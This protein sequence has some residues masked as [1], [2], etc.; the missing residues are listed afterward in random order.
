ML[1]RLDEWTNGKRPSAG[2]L[3]ELY[4]ATQTSAS[5]RNVL[6]APQKRAIDI[7][8]FMGRWYVIGHIPTFLDRGTINNT[9]DY[10]WDE[11]KQ[12][13]NVKF[14]YTVVGK[15]ESVVTQTA[16]MMNDQNTEWKL[17]IKV[18]FLPISAPFLLLHCSDDYQT[19]IVG[20]PKRSFLYLMARSPKID[21]DSY[22]SLVSRSARCGYD[23]D[24]L[25]KVPQNLNKL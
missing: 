10:T 17:S 22:I 4:Q 12:Q 25:T 20:E 16:K 2:S 7:K 23:I 24:L 3:M 11:A 19:C 21:E 6:C 1:Q 8:R 13:V 15:K 9:E 14:S 18:A 5:V